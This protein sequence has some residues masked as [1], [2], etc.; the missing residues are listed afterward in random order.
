MRTLMYAFL[1]LAV[2]VLIVVCLLGFVIAGLTLLVDKVRK[3]IRAKKKAAR[4]W[5]PFLLWVLIY[6]IF[7]N[8]AYKVLSYVLDEGLW[9]FT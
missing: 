4:E 3:N 2:Y 8:L 6:I 1:M 7:T 5:M 9:I